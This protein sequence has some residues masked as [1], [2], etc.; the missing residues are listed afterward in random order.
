[1]QG[2][3]SPFSNN[4]MQH[5]QQ[6]QQQIQMNHQLDHL[7]PTSHDDFLKHMLSALPPSSASSSSWNLDPNQKPFWGDLN[8]PSNSD[9]TAPSG[10][11]NVAFP[12]D[13]HASLASK[14]RNHQ[15][16]AT[17]SPLTA[18]AAALMLQQQL[19]MSRGVAAADSGIL[20]MFDSSRNDVV[21]G[22]SSFK[23]PNP[24]SQIK[25]LLSVFFSPLMAL[26]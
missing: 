5:Q 1:M 20:Q 2:L 19:L 23:S 10:V 12:Y 7:D 26:A 6:H 9:E 3:N 25:T 17:S 18:K 24:V 8:P 13:E 16:S 14:F 11:D 4:H 21:D 15:I 22:S